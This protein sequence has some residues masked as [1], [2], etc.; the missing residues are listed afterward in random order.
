M[1]GMMDHF[2]LQSTSSTVR[3]AKLLKQRQKFGVS[4]SL[5]SK[6]L[7]FSL[8]IFLIGFVVMFYI[9]NSIAFVQSISLAFG[10]AGEFKY[11][12]FEIIY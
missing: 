10:E 8:G 11:N 6:T 1:G 2:Q 7:L 12:S 9:S 5:I 4:K 3:F